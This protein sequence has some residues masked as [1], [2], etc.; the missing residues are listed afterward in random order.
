MEG[1]G[2]AVPTPPHCPGSLTQLRLHLPRYFTTSQR[3]RRPSRGAAGWDGAGAEGLCPIHRPAPNPGKARG[4]PSPA[5][6]GERP[7]A[8]GSAG[9]ALRAPPTRSP[10]GPDWGNTLF[11][12]LPFSRA[13]AP[14]ACP[15][16]FRD[17]AAGVCPPVPG[18]SCPGARRQPAPA[19]RPTWPGTG[20]FCERCAG[21]LRCESTEINSQLSEYALLQWEEEPVVL[22]ASLYTKELIDSK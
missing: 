8:G 14:R 10:N 22:A 3:S 18:T 9:A 1:A 20:C 17:R 13:S 21:S 6:P 19:A 4:R 2:G 5:L 16:G 7:S 12:Q 11:L 15:V